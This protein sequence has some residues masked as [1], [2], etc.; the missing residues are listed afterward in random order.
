MYAK[1]TEKRRDPHPICRRTL[2][3]TLPCYA[4]DTVAPSSERLV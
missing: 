4:L 1:N 3:A 2:K